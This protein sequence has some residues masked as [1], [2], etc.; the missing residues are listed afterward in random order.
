MEGVDAHPLKK[1]K[2]YQGGKDDSLSMELSNFNQSKNI[3]KES[4]MGDSRRNPEKT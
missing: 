1:I 2:Q 3:T 4:A